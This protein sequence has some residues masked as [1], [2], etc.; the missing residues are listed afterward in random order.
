[1]EF[2]VTSSSS[3]DT[4]YVLLQSS[5]TYCGKPRAGVVEAVVVTPSDSVFCGHLAKHSSRANR[6]LYMWNTAS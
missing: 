5:T 1:M 2:L 6:S 3:H 4:M